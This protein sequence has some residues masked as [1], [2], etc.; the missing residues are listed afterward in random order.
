M[1]ARCFSPRRRSVALWALAT[2]FPLQRTLA[3]QPQRQLIADMHSHATMFSRDPVLNLRNEMDEAGVTLVAWALVDDTP[4]TRTT[5]KGIKQIRQPE[6]GQLWSYFQRRVT[7]Y[8]DALRQWNLPK[9]LSASDIDAALRGEPH[10]VMAS[11]AANFL[12]GQPER[13]ALAH[14]MGLRHLQLVHFIES[15]LGDLQT[16]AP[17]FLGLPD[18][19]LK[20]IQEC[21]RLGVLV[22]LAHSAPSFVDAALAASDAT[23]IWSHSW[24][25]RSGGSW[26][27]WPNVARAL[28]PDQARRIVAHGGV[29]GLWTVRVHSDPA[30]H[31]R[32]AETYADEILRMVDLLGPQGVAF[33]TDMEGAG[34]DA[35]FKRYVDLRAVADSLARRNI[36]ASVLHDV[37]IGNYARVLKKAISV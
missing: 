21:K 29:V 24:I 28:S 31:V 16:E 1:N 22:D 12:E 36:P 35:V 5:P 10:I 34:T 4:F 27:D 18:V 3:Q 7:R 8:D 32:D 30:Y 2:A 23:M 14:A 20:V 37:C 19:T 33:G 9:A 15:P 11:E 25:S 26:R 6:P 17:R 13:V